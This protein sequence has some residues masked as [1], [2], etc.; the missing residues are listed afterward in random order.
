MAGPIVGENGRSPASTPDK[1]IYWF[2]QHWLLAFT[3]IL[4]I[5]VGLPWLAPIFM[6]LGWARA[7]ETIYLIY[8]TQCHQMPQRSFF[9]FGDNAMLPLSTIQ[10]LWSDS[11]NPLVLRQFIGNTDVGWKVAWS[12]RM[13]YMYTSLLIF[14]FA[15][16][17]LRKR[18][19]PLPWWGLLL[20]LLPMAADGFTHFISDI[21]GGIGGGFRFTN[22]W[23]ATLTSSAFPATFYAGDTLGSFNSWMRLITGILFGLGVV[24]FA[25][26]HLHSIFSDNANRIA[27][28]FQQAGKGIYE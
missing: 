1:I 26:P 17:P 23:L 3:L 6:A 21:V 11:N 13:V 2:S 9:L 19:K 8:S 15:F 24:W 22:A 25:Y 4:L 20:F 12:D 14:G 10:A 5:F 27:P 18:L 28:K 16:W 7:G